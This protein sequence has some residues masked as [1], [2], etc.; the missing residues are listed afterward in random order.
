M[1]VNATVSGNLLGNGTLIV[2]SDA[3]ETGEPALA[4]RISN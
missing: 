1:A 4:A 3:P 2:L